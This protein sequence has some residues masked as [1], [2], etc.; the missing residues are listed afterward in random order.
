LVGGLCA[1]VFGEP[2]TVN[3]FGSAF[4]SGFQVL[5]LS[6]GLIVLSQRRL[7]SLV[8]EGRPRTVIGPLV[9]LWVYLLIR[10]PASLDPPAA[11][12]QVLDR[13]ALVVVMIILASG[14]IGEDRY[15]LV[16]AG[17]AGMAVVAI[18]GIAQRIG[19]HPF[20]DPAI[21]EPGRPRRPLG[22]HNLMGGY[23]AAWLPV[24]AAVALGERGWRKV[25]W[26][27]VL[28]VDLAAFLL[29]ESRGAWLV[30]A[31][32]LLAML[33][34]LALGGARRVTEV[35]ARD[36][37]GWQVLLALS[38]VVAIACAGPVVARLS[39]GEH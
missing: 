21:W 8:L 7:A 19:I 20:L 29:M 35:A 15:R 14:V 27:A 6:L 4:R 33:P 12:L 23:L 13:T 16:R 39:T 3:A 31:V 36:R 9:A 22:T 18:W 10:A 38:V 17:L 28:L 34:W 1:L 5:C 25:I 26:G 32:T 30:M 37:R 24:A 11:L 2:L